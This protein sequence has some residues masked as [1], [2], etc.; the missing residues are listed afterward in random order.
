MMR[1]LK[2]LEDVITVTVVHPIWQKTHPEKDD[3]SSFVETS[4]LNFDTK[5]TGTL[6]GFNRLGCLSLCSTL[7]G[8]LVMSLVKTKNLL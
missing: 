7:D 2:G 5:L 6:F 3:V 4:D 1:A 8:S